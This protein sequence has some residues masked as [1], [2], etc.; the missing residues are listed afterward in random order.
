MH[1]S[2]I[3]G[4]FKQEGQ[5]FKGHSWL[6]NAFEA[7]LEYMGA[8]FRQTDKKAKGFRK[9]KDSLHAGFA[10]LP[11]PY[12]SATLPHSRPQVSGQANGWQG[13]AALRENTLVI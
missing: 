1:I 3:L 13:E 11:T 4:G 5:K 9:P 2:P 10:Y 8:S 12:D 7:S 6:H